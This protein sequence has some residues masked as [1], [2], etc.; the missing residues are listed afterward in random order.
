MEIK[1]MIRP[2]K[3]RL[4]I[5][6]LIRASA[7]GIFF[8][9]CLTLVTAGIFRFIPDNKYAMQSMYLIIAI[10][11]GVGCAAV[12][13]TIIYIVRYRHGI[14][15]IAKRIDELGLEERVSTMVE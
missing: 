7:I 12:V 5:E 11:S 15:E 4:I 3:R 1:Q 2:Y 14:S 8:G 10:A 13:G 6:S 9:L